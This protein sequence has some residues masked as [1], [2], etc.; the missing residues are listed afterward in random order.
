MHDSRGSTDVHQHLW[1]PTLVE[2]LRARRTPP[3]LEGWTLVLDG[4]PPYDID[5]HDHDITSRLALEPAGRSRVLVSLST[6]LGI[7]NLPPDQ[8][9][10]LLDAWRAGNALWPTRV[11]AWAS[12]N[13]IEPDLIA[14]KADFDD[15]F[16]GLQVGADLLR[17]PAALEALAPTL[18]V[19]ASADKPVLVHPGPAAS[20]VGTPTW[21]AP[22]VDYVAQ[23]Q[24][25]WWSWH[26][27]GRSLLADLRICFAAGAGLAPIHHERLTARGGGQLGPVDRATFVETSSYGPQAIDA[28]IRVLGVD[29]LVLGSD[30]P[31]AEPLDQ[32]GAQQTRPPGG[33]RTPAHR[34]ALG[35]AA[36]YAITTIN[37]QR[38][39]E[40]DQ[41]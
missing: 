23:L 41:R 13:A 18:A 32:G 9:A 39:I 37:P 22:V 16:V 3:R 21:W 26:A 7:E 20:P 17:T 12:T 29:V 2:A 24:A 30:R 6:P 27:V 14:L 34:L 36:T 25:A 35:E 19:C 10:P 31:Y 28:L 15:G 1:P 40:G 4:E 38:L 8:S 33:I 5:P 11:G